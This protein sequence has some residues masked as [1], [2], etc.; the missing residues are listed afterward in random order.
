MDSLGGEAY[1]AYKVA[2]AVHQRWIVSTKPCESFCC[3][4]SC[5]LQI[6]SCVSRRVAESYFSWFLAGGNTISWRNSRAVDV[7][8]CT[9]G[10]NNVHQL[11]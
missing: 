10:V 8:Q 5:D 6:R 7:S 4:R 1:S 2:G 9:D 3:D 11:L